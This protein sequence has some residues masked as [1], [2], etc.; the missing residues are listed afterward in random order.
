MHT[1]MYV[2]TSVCGRMRNSAST[3]VTLNTLEI[4]LKHGTNTLQYIGIRC[5]TAKRS[6]NFVFAL[7]KNQRMPTY[8]LYA[9]H[10]LDVRNRYGLHTL[11]FTFQLQVFK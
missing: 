2:S 5:Y 4:S 1:L 8:C 3:L 11:I 6:Q 7:K 9:R 10:K